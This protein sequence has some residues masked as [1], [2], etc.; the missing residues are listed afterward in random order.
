MS[1]KNELRLTDTNAASDSKGRTWGLEGGLFWWLIGGIGA[2]ITLFFVLLVV[3]SV[4]LATSL[5]V[6]L[7]PLLLCLA[8]IFGLRQG[9]PPGYDRD[10]F[11]YLLTGRGFGP[12]SNHTKHPL[13][14][15]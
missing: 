14:E 11:E 7:V 8:Y 13:Y 9:K 10:C 5:L 15:S 12:E 3:M 4:S 2:G 6:A 1:A